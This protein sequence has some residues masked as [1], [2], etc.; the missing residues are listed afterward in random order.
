MNVRFCTIIDPT[1]VTIPVDM[2]ASLLQRMKL[3]ESWYEVA[4]VV[5]CTQIGD[6]ILFNEPIAEYTN[7]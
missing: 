2:M 4:I 6:G 7:L 3:C 5:Q 1:R